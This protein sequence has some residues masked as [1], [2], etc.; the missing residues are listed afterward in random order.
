MFLL[1]ME[2]DINLAHKCADKAATTLF[3]DLMIHDMTKTIIP[4]LQLVKLELKRCDPEVYE[5]L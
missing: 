3:N 2:N 4:F 5:I 1:T